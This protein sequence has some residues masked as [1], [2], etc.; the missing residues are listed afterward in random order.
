MEEA[1]K[2]LS[3]DLTTSKQQAEDLQKLSDDNLKEW[4]EKENQFQTEVCKLIFVFAL[5][6]FCESL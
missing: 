6:L 3:S 1:S 2:K 5:E 4:S